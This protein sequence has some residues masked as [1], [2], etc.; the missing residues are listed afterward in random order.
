MRRFGRLKRPPGGEGAARPRLRQLA[1][2]PQPW[3]SEFIILSLTTQR[4]VI[5]DR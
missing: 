3:G 1:G 2:P 5:S 4:G